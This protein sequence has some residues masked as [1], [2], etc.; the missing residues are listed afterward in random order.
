MRRRKRILL[1]CS[2]FFVIALSLLTGCATLPSPEK[3][4]QE[5]SGYNLP[6]QSDTESS[7]V[8]VVRPSSLGTLVR[9]NVFLDDKEVSSEMGWNRGSQ[10]IYFYVNPGK[11]TIFSIA[12]NW[13]EISIDL[14]AGET[15]FVKQNPEMGIIM[16]RNSLEII[17]EIEGKYY[18]KNAK[19]GN[20]ISDGVAKLKKKEIKQETVPQPKT[21]A[22]KVNM[23]K[24]DKLREGGVIS[25]DEYKRAKG[26]I[27]PQTDST[28]TDKQLQELGEL[29]KGGVVAEADYNKAKKRITELQ[30]LNELHQSGVLSEEEYNKA[31]TRLKEK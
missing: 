1:H 14:K 21:K 28:D 16:A 3:M 7:L 30:K 19:V 9:F 25:A 31:K 10:Y 20:I 23:E 5:V 15:A 17:P 26:N 4:A 29:R 12:E 24:L 2:F 13:A 8:Y 22:P 11:H 18:V 6:K 27:V